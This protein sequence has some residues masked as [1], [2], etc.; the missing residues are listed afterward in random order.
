MQHIDIMHSTDVVQRVASPAQRDAIAYRL[1]Q[2][3]EPCARLELERALQQ[4]SAE[5]TVPEHLVRAAKAVFPARLHATGV[6]R[7]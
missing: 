7:D 2:G 5:P 6:L 3:C 1:T 4:P